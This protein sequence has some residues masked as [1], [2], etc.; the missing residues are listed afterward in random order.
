MARITLPQLERH[1]FSAADILRGRMDASEYRDYIFGMLFLKRSSDEFQPE[2][3]RVY[4]EALDKTGERAK[5]LARADD[6]DKYPRIFYVPPRARWWKGPHE[7]PEHPDHPVPGISMLTD[8]VG[9]NLDQALVALQGSHPRLAGVASHISFNEI[10]GTKPRFT[11]S[12]LRSLIRHFSLY[13]LRNE[14]FEFPDMLGAA[15]EYLLGRFADS[16]GQRGGEFYTPREVVRMMVRL[17]DPEA[18]DSVYDPCAGS[19][20]ML[21]AAQEHVEEHGGAPGDLSING[22]DKNGPSWSMASMNMVLHGIREFDLQHGDTLADPL[23]LTEAGRL[24]TFTKVLSNPPFSLNYDAELVEAAD[25]KHGRRMKWGATPENGKKADLMFVQH[26]VT[27]LEARGVAATVMPHGVLFRS[28]KERDIRIELLNDDCIEAVIGLGPNLFYGTGIPGCILVLRPPHRKRD[29]LD[30]QGKLERREKQVLFINADREFRAA[31]NQNELGPEHVEKLVTVFKGWREEPG[32]SRVV[33]VE[34]LLAADANLNIRRWVDNSPPAEPQDVRAHLYGGVPKAEIEAKA[35]LF[36][37]YG[38]DA[39]GLFA[40][41]AGDEEYVDFLPEGPDA[42]AERIGGLAAP[43]EALLRKAYEEWWAK[44]P[45]HFTALGEDRRL[46]VLRERLVSGFTEAV[47]GAGVLDEYTTAGIL[48]DW[49]TLTRYDLKAL[50]A[51]GYERVL[52]GWVDSV[53]TMVEPVMPDVEDADS[54]PGRTRGRAK[55]SVTA[56]DRRR[57]LD[58]PVVRALIP[59]FLDEVARAD[60]AVAVADAA[61]KTA[62]ENLAAAQPP[63]AD[64][65]ADGEDEPEERTPVTPEELARLEEVVTRRR[66]ER[67]AASK[68]RSALDA[69][70]LPNLRA[71][72]EVAK[73]SEGGAER[74]VLEVLDADLSARLEA[75]VASGRRELIAAFR[76]WAEKYAVSLEALEADSAGAAGEFGDWLKELGYAR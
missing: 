47:G 76:R 21:I 72:A 67:T 35:G 15:Y 64:G 63:T 49:W 65:D 25:E 69:C 10:V 56:A 73:S 32:Y 41:R 27:V 28:G 16:A 54:G 23:H 36:S 6:P 70:F 11:N 17:V 61:Y 19:G 37:A 30:K 58:Q 46:M 12:E 48:A 40:D 2:W 31:R 53:E 68:K 55:T 18:G 26:M 22:Q 59:E 4:A 8:K 57:A 9:E 52:D 39:S 24:R 42:T 60:A 74:V 62:L 66:K 50:A 7:D 71:A 14:D 34:D 1:L 75:A 5:A 33:S 13:Q 45:A 3:D 51:G 38:V 44:Q 20:G 43:K 29:R